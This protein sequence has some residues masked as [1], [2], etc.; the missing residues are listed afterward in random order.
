MIY[1]AYSE[2]LG[3]LR[4]LVKCLGV[5]VIA[6][7]RLF[8]KDKIVGSNSLPDRASARSH[9]DLGRAVAGF[10]GSKDEQVLIANLEEDLCV[11][12]EGDTPTCWV[13]ERVER[14]A[15]AIDTTPPGEFDAV[16]EDS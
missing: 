14:V 9:T 10:Q 15:V 4:P 11:G 8:V 5:I 13:S 16:D 12:T 6:S 3:A 2:R 7:T 1:G